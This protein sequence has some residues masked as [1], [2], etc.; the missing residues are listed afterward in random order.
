[1]KLTPDNLRIG[2]DG[3]TWLFTERNKTLVPVRI[4]LLF[5]AKEIIDK[6]KAHPRTKVT[7]TLFPTITNQKLNSYLKE[8]ADLCGIKKNLTFH[9]ARH[10]FATTVTLTN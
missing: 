5:K 10:T 4:P 6:Y 2:I 8:I 7:G 1:M 3:K 9:L